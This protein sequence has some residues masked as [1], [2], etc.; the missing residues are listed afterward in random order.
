MDTNNP[1]VSI[2]YLP[3]ADNTVVTGD[4]SA[5]T[6]AGKL[7]ALD[8]TGKI[9]RH[10]VPYSLL[11]VTSLGV[12][13][14]ERITGDVRL[15]G[16]GNISVTR[17][18]N[19]FYISSNFRQGVSGISVGASALSGAILFIAGNGLD[20]SSDP[21]NNAITFKNEGVLSINGLTEDIQFISAN[22]ITVT[23]V[24]PNTITLSL[25]SLQWSQFDSTASARARRV[26]TDEGLFLGNNDF[27][28]LYQFNNKTIVRGS[29]GVVFLDPTTITEAIVSG[30]NGIFINE[31]RIHE[32]SGNLL[33]QS[34]SGAIVFSS[35]TSLLNV[36][37]IQPSFT[38]GAYLVKDLSSG[39]YAYTFAHNANLNPL[40]LMVTQVLTGA[41]GA[42]IET[43]RGQGANLVNEYGYN[44]SFT[45][46]AVIVQAL[47][48]NEA[49]ESKFFNVRCMF[50]SEKEALV[51]PPPSS[52]TSAPIQPTVSIL[53]V[54]SGGG[55]ATDILLSTRPVDNATSYE[56]YRVADDYT[57]ETSTPLLSTS[58]DSTFKVTKPGIFLHRVRALNS[59]GYS[60][61]T[62][63]NV[64]I[65]PL[66]P[67]LIG[68]LLDL[69][70]MGVLFYKKGRL[71]VVHQTGLIR[72]TDTLTGQ[73]MTLETPVPYTPPSSSLGSYPPVVSTPIVLLNL[74]P[75]ASY[76][77]VARAYL[78]EVTFSDISAPLDIYIPAV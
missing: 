48:E 4:A 22:G 29:S 34:A 2:E 47:L 21:V 62:D 61:Y 27:A 74:L 12:D 59:S 51:L 14:G 28:S 6:Q 76:R 17:T 71:S 38:S 50:A 8:A 54:P 49:S 19:S 10:F 30:G 73:D 56:W 78:D 18:G 39:L 55:F 33:I 43:T 31:S 16:S 52:V 65:R 36:S 66:V 64:S 41:G 77:L 60:E 57:W 23:A 44:V 67:V 68:P 5:I 46:N 42:V 75:N 13:D 3:V 40:S 7:V 1:F 9:N 37:A 32:I 63:F 15:Y 53:G 70:D 35:G 69:E 58:T 26:V 45:K 20:I 24:A 72:V 11:S 25:D